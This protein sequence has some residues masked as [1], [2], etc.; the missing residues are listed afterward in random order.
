MLWW[1]N[2]YEWRIKL[3]WNFVQRSQKV[4]NVAQGL[5]YITKCSIPSILTITLI[6]RCTISIDTPWKCKT[7]VTSNAHPKNEYN[8]SEGEGILIISFYKYYSAN[9][10]QWI[11][12]YTHHPTLQAQW[13]GAL[14]FP[15]GPHGG[16]HTGTLQGF[17]SSLGLDFDHPEMHITSPSSLQ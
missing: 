3:N 5:T 11:L 4:W 12:N 7:F 14:Q 17:S 6:S 2:I 15:F 1:E 10:T 8:M 16:L 13:F 9:H